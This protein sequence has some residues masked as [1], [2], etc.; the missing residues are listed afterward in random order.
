MNHKGFA[1]CLSF[2]VLCASASYGL[3]PCTNC[4][5]GPHLS[6]VPLWQVKLL[7]GILQMLLYS[8]YYCD[9]LRDGA[10]ERQTQ[11]NPIMNQA[12]R[13]YFATS[14]LLCFINSFCWFSLSEVHNDTVV[15]ILGWILCCEALGY[16]G[17]FAFTFSVNTIENAIFSAC[18]GRLA[19]RDCQPQVSEVVLRIARGYA[20]QGIENVKRGHGLIVGNAA[21]I[22]RVGHI[23]SHNDFLGQA[24]DILTEG[25]E[26]I[27][28]RHMN[29]DGM[30]VIDERTGL[31]VANDVFAD[32]LPEC[33]GGARTAAAIWFSSQV[34]GCI[35]CM[36][37]QD[38]NGEVLRF[39]D[40]RRQ[41]IQSDGEQAAE[42]HP[43]HE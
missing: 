3:L 25:G 8:A 36:V 2:F 30:I 21:K 5:V 27:L 13:K 19:R 37:S 43:S 20:S 23:N 12:F 1:S 6:H 16:I 32:E 41:V 39:V 42:L 29:L 34:P 24:A 11:R 10:H 9:C 28:R 31:V 17:A 14:A 26:E 7:N 35:V 22:L 40:G 38:S 18:R 15:H 33:N 4:W